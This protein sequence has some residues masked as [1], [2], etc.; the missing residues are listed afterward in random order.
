MNIISKMWLDVEDN[1]RETGIKRW[2][3]K[4]MNR[5]EWRK[6]CEATKVLKER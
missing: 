1:L 3:I 5:T 6:M 4:A 2:R